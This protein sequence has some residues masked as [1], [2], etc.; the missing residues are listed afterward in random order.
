MAAAPSA[1]A[2]APAAEPTQFAFQG[3]VWSVG[4]RL[5]AGRFAT[6]YSCKCTTDGAKAPL[7]A[8][9]TQLAGLSPW[10]RAQLSEELA[11]WSTLK[12][13]NVVRLHGSFT[14][15]TRHVLF[16]EMCH[17]G[18]LFDRIISLSS[19]CEEQAARQVGQVLSA[20]AHMHAFGVLHRDLKP[21]NLLLESDAEDAPVKVADFGASKLCIP[22]GLSSGARTPCGSLGYAAPEQLRCLRFAAEPATVPA[23]DKEVDLWSL[24]VITYILLSG[25]M[26]FDPT[27]YS[28]EALER[29][30]SLEFPPALFG[31]IS[32]EAQD[33]IQALLQLDPT[34]RLSASQAQSHRWLAPTAAGDGG[35][36]VGGEVVGGEV[37]GG[38]ESSAGSRPTPRTTPLATPGRLKELHSSGKLKKAWDT[39]ALPGGRVKAA[40]AQA[41]GGAGAGVSEGEHERERAHKRAIEALLEDERPDIA[42]ML[43]PDISRKIRRGSGSGGPDACPPAKTED[44]K[45]PSGPATSA[46]QPDAEPAG[47]DAAGPFT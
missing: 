47:G 7:A 20:L 8:K 6:V 29:P 46:T 37:D 28:A 31:S 10:G 42:L 32:A 12:H 35:E 18:E 2:D 15:A 17:G 23:Y 33:F 11:I 40:A 38:G 45:A 41:E 3:H 26:P 21:E 9:V 27:G 25:A 43:P 4:S 24:G 5:G 44:G 30:N 36:V 39:A 19:F 14:D 16:L 22:G 13:P 1:P 34:A